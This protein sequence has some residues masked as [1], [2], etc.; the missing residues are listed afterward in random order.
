MTAVSKLR[1]EHA[2]NLIGTSILRAPTNG[3]LDFGEEQAHT[4]SAPTARASA[5]KRKVE[6]PRRRLTVTSAV[7]NP[8]PTDQP[9]SR[10][11]ARESMVRPG[12]ISS[13]LGRKPDPTN[14]FRPQN[15]SLPEVDSHGEDAH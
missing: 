13:N 3:E 2:P 15:P 14:G 6:A 1:H 4:G 10:A 11:H 7:K 12:R 5:V 9:K 8:V